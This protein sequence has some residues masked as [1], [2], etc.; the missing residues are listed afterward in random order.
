MAAFVRLDGYIAMADTKNHYSYW[1]PV[2]AIR[3]GGTDGNPDT[4]DDPAWTPLRGTPANPDYAS[5][6]SIEGGAGAEVLKQ[7]FGTDRMNFQDCSA[8][9]PEP[10][11]DTTCDGSSP[12]YRSYSSFSQAA[13]ENAYSRILIG[14]HFRKSVEEATD[15]GRRIGKRAANL[16][17]RPVH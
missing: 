1:R 12:V 9:L 15:Y 17:F 14:F 7:F 13:V 2:T 16:Y 6:H 5:G 3:N 11:A 4:A 8:T 10:L